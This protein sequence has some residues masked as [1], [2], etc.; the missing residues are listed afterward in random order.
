[1]DKIASK[2]KIAAWSCLPG[3]KEK[4]EFDLFDFAPDQIASLD[5]WLRAEKPQV[6]MTVS[7]EQ[8]KL[9]IDDITAV[10]RLVNVSLRTGGQK[11]KVADFKSPAERAQTLKNLVQN[12]TPVLVTVCE[13]QASL[14][15]G[16]SSAA[17]EEPV[18]VATQ[19]RTITFGRGR[20]ER[21]ELAVESNG[22]PAVRVLR[23]ACRTAK[24]SEVLRAEI[25]EGEL[26]DTIS[27]LQQRVTE[28]FTNRVRDQA[29]TAISVAL[30]EGFDAWC[31]DIE[32][33]N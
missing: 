24:A 30:T 3:Q 26:P 2:T 21:V 14:P 11:I 9:Q 7:V 22:D 28:W 32:A 6:R 19:Q 23:A 15:F 10:V 27:L 12:E 17:A 31:A 33:A 13:Y 16:E 29:M 1:M 25:I 18:Q 8:K 20:R 4:I 5:R